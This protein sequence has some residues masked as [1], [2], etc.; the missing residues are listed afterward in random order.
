M[1]AIAIIAV[2]NEARYIG[3][4]LRH[5]AEQ[6][7]NFVIIDNEST[8]DTRAEASHFAGHGLVHIETF[9][10]NGFYD[11]VGLLK[12]KETIARQ[13]DAE[14]FMHFD[15]DE[16]PESPVRGERFMDW[17]L[18]IDTEGYSAINFDEFVFLPTNSDENYEGTDYV[19][20][21]RKYFFFEPHPQRLVRAWR[22]APDIDL[23]SSGGHA[24]RF[25]GCMVYPVN[26]ALRHYIALSEAYLRKKYTHERIYS[27]AEVAKGWHGWRAVFGQVCVQLPAPCEL[28]DTSTDGGWDRSRPATRHLFI[29]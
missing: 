14:W 27:P 4:C 12:R 3:R 23:S 16:I 26:F 24:A 25:A 10:Y 15:A 17:I 11:W 19:S 1:K 2:R 21:M 28:V 29:R 20:E 8:D 18:K 13:L 9:P 5:L 7:I 22:K 6:D